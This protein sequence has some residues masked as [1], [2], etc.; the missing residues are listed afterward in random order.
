MKEMKDRTA[1]L[2]EAGAYVQG[3]YKGGDPLESD[4]GLKMSRSLAAS[5]AA[6]RGVP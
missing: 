4:A 1:V 3:D 2:V 5:R 6:K